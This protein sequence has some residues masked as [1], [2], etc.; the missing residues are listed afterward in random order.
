[1]DE[2]VT[3]QP[4]NIGPGE[5][6]NSYLPLSIVACILCNFCCLGTV[7]LAKSVQSNNANKEGRVEEAQQRGMTA[8]KCAIASIVCSIILILAVA[9]P[10]IVIFRLR[11][12]F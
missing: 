10:L 12:K 11:D 9:I 4:K 6:V 7:A 3:T 8:R 5:E 2:V 1:M